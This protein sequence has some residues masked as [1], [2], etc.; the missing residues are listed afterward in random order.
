MNS[1]RLV[2]QNTRIIH[3]DRLAVAE[4]CDDD[5]EADGGFGG[6]YAH[7]HKNKK[8][9]GHVGVITR[10]GDECQV[11]GVEHQLDAHK[12]PDRVA[13]KNYTDSADGE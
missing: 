3:I 5:A 13:L 1:E 2:L 4:K 6:G 7:D 11:D 12:H 9:A 10:K 8:L